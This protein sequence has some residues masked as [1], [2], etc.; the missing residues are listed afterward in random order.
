MSRRKPVDRSPWVPWSAASTYSVPAATSDHHRPLNILRIPA[1]R[2]SITWYNHEMQNLL[3][4]EMF[5]E[6]QNP[7]SPSAIQTWRYTAPSR[8]SPS[9]CPQLVA[10]KRTPH[11]ASRKGKVRTLAS[12]GM[13]RGFLVAGKQRPAGRSRRRWAI[14]EKGA[15]E[16]DRRGGERRRRRQRVAWLVKT[17]L[18][19]IF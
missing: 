19:V 1:L 14:R 16:G 13:E 17:V 4:T 7:N 9:W 3:L 15:A 2:C 5:T 11:G 18:V 10:S 12:W 8:L 6:R